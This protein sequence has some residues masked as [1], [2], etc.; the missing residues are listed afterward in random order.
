MSA[1]AL[2]T[3]ARLPVWL[4][5]LSWI[6]N[7]LR[8]FLTGVAQLL[9]VAIF[10]LMFGEVSSRYLL[11][12]SLLVTWEF[13]AYF[14]GWLVF[15][16]AAD[17]AA[18]SKHVRVSLLVEHCGRR[19]AQAIEI[20]GHVIALLAAA[21]VAWALTSFALDAFHRGSVTQT[22]SKVPIFAIYGVSAVGAIAVTVTVLLR[23]TMLCLGLGLPAEREETEIEDS[24]ECL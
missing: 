21:V 19:T 2:A 4:R 1:P 12:V 10:V 23:V 14:L 13:S 18:R 6:D 11:G 5:C 7:A 16:G 3:E 24:Q 8:R 17:T 15:L 9:V 22:I 20:V